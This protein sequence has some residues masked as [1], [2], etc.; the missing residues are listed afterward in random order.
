MVN[1]L[2]NENSSALQTVD[3]WSFDKYDFDKYDLINTMNTI[4]KYTHKKT[5]TL[6]HVIVATDQKSQIF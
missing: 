5:P 3:E 1:I 2:E 4:Y 6:M